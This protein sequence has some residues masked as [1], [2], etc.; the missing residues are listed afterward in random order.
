MEVK[1]PR[2]GAYQ[3]TQQHTLW[4]EISFTRQMSLG[5]VDK[6]SVSGKKLVEGANQRGILFYFIF[7]IPPLQ[8]AKGI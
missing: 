7:A 8:Q 1:P 5:T 3:K 6:G 2:Q 4:K